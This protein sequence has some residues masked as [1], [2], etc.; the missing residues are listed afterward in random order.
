[1]RPEPR[2]TAIISLIQLVMLLTVPAAFAHADEETD[3]F[4]GFELRGIGPALMSGRISHLELHPDDP[5]TWY[6]AVGSGGVWKTVNAG[7]T[8]TPLFDDQVSYSIGTIALDPQNPNVVWVGTGEDVGGR[9]VGYGDGLY[10]S[11]DGGKN[12][13]HRGLEN[14]EHIARIVIH[15]DDSNVIYV[16]AQGPLWAP[17]GERG[18]FRSTD[19]G[20]TWTKTLGD[21]EYT[22]VTDLV[23]DPRDPDVL[24]AATWQHH[25]T[26]AAYMGGG[27]KTRI[28]RSDDGGVTWREL[29]EQEHGG[30]PQGNL[31]KIGLAISPHDPDSI[32][33]A[34]ELDRR[35]GAVYRSTDRGES[36]EKR[37]DTV[38]GGT[39]PHYYQELYASPHHEGRIYLVSNTSQISYDGGATFEPMS[40]E[41]KHVDDHAIAFRDDDPDYLM[42]GCDGGIYET[43]DH[44]DTWR[45]VANLPVTQFYKVDVDDDEP[46][47]N[48]YGGTQ[49]NNSQGGPSRT[50]NL[51]G[52]RNSDWFITL[53]GDGHDQATEPGNPDIVYSEW[54]QGN[55]VRYDRKTG[56]IVYIKPQAGPGEPRERFNWDS[57][58][59][60]S[61][62]SPTRLYFASQRVWRSDDRGD[63][64]T[65][66]S[67]DLSR[68]E[69]RMLL[70]IMGRQQSWDAPWDMYAMSQFNTI[71]S[72]AESP[73]AE[74]VLYAGTDDGL[75]HASTDGGEN[76]TRI[77]VSDLPGVPER[78]FVN[79]IKADL[80]DAQTVY[81]A[82]DHHKSGDYRP[83]LLKS[84]NGGQSWTSIAGDLP[85]RHLVWRV[86]QDHVNPQLLFA[87]TEF[88]I[89]F[90]TDG[91]EA[92]HQLDG[93]VPTISFRDL[94]IQRLDDYSPLR[95]VTSELLEQEAALFGSRRAWWYL[96]QRP[97][98]SR[99]KA[100]QGDAFFT[101]PNPPFG[102]V[103]TYYLRD[104]M[105]TKE[106]QRQEAEKPLI[107][108]GEDTPF[109]GWDAVREEQREAGPAVILTIRDVDGEVVRH[110]EDGPTSKGFHRIAWDLRY[111]ATQAIGVQG[112]WFAP[113]VQGIMAPPG[114]YTA[115]L[116]RRV[117][118]VVTPLAG[119]VDFDVEQM[120]EGTLPSAEPE[121][122]VAF[123]SR[124]DDLRRQTTAV[125]QLLP[126]LDQR[127]AEL[128]EARAR[129][130]SSAVD[131]D[132]MQR[133]I[134]NELYEIKRELGGTPEANVVLQLEH[135]T[136]ANR[137]SFVT[138][139]TSFSTY[140]PTPSH[141]EAMDLAEGQFADVKER[142]IRLTEETV[143]AFERALVEAG[144]PWV[145]GMPI[146]IIE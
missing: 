40:N 88:G 80:F 31:G 124:I 137:L 61:P 60:I 22:G 82:L 138:T 117:D 123:W 72:L 64:W 45:F 5:N 133:E 116:S 113:Q 93:G 111:P 104:S 18:F 79:D 68:D 30:L 90:T 28:H 136:V 95:D 100:S 91:G 53:F 110:L 70:P 11:A 101:A 67:G 12:W 128:D 38:S 14:S 44:T 135:P 126:K 89:F 49:D 7:T 32:Y 37:S 56:E 131:L 122:V 127:V 97:L 103:F 98:G 85:D 25:R 55:L 27:P 62:H 13:E 8:W 83:Y 54:Q 9:H 132:G 50:D 107:E 65:V 19:G 109:P 96:E 86:I 51:H 46:F 120:R 114:R 69:D 52:I 2:F 73:V 17:G 87:G 134:A 115:E 48:V 42:F 41:N 63:T 106:G 36:W 125:S 119:P 129:T 142:L 144:A 23:M 121:A 74:G 4:A 81:V 139:G 57:P 26:V 16:A 92:W 105:L 94:E 21:E 140:G 20:E 33:A 6:V 47:Y 3:L 58:I 39:G 66:I 130:R 145:P 112:N 71:T 118:G 102:A 141:I 108:A 24:Y 84:T 143:P 34:I 99:P 76:W 59:L 1:M 78:A 35:K 75:I 43:F 15:P 77:D 10:R 146:S 29:G